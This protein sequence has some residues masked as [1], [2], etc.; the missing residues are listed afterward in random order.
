MTSVIVLEVFTFANFFG[1]NGLKC[2]GSSLTF[3]AHLHYGKNCI[4]LVGFREQNKN[5]L[6]W[7]NTNLAPI[8]A[9]V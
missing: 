5:I 6:S 3:K 4:K 2:S 1:K 8:F 9:I 7:K